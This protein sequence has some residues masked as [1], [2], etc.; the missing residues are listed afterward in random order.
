MEHTR[1]LQGRALLRKGR[2]RLGRPLLIRIGSPSF[3]SPIG[4]RR[5]GFVFEIGAP[6]SR[7]DGGVGLWMHWADQ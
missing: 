7:N 3:R 4:S 6:A 1:G 2:W 5:E